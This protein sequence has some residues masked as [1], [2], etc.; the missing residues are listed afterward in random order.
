MKDGKLFGKIHILDILV[1]AVAVMIV[2]TAIGRFTGAEIISFGESEAVTLRY[3]VMSY[4]YEPEF[5]E[6]M[7]VGDSLATESEFLNGTIV[8]IE[9]I[10]RIETQVDNQGN[11]VS[12]VHPTEKYALITMEAEATHKNPIYKVGDQEIREGLPHFVM[13]EYSNISGIITEIEVLK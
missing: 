8:A 10:D 7:T 11:E 4:S 12:G 6:S 3:Q 1:L 13:T 2:V 5:F 9:I